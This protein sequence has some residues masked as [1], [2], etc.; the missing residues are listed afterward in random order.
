MNYN[1]SLLPADDVFI[2]LATSLNREYFHNSV[3]L[4]FITDLYIVLK[5]INMHTIST[6]K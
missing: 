6:K 5:L 2:W 3:Y 4:R 1:A